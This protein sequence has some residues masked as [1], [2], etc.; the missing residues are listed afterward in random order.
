MRIK[1]IKFIL[2]TLSF[3]LMIITGAEAEPSAPLEHLALEYQMQ[4]AR[5]DSDNPAEKERLYLKLIE[6][7]PQT[8]AAEEALWA[9]ANLYLDDFEEPRLS[10]AQSVLE[11]FLSNYSSSRWLPHVESKLL[12][13]YEGTDNNVRVI[14]LCEHILKRRMPL[15]ARLSLELRCAEAYSALK[16]TDKARDYYTRIIEHQGS[17]NYPEAAIAKKQLGYLKNH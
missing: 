14:E 7:C 9:L 4:I 13:L 11:S 6:T 16:K 17:E 2:F 12:W 5:T 1:Q 8:E 15:Q 10:D 3:L